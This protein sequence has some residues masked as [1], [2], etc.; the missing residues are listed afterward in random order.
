[1]SRFCSGVSIVNFQQV[2]SCSVIWSRITIIQRPY[3]IS[4]M[5]V[6][7]KTDIRQGPKNVSNSNAM[8]TGS[9]IR[10]EEKWIVAF[11]IVAKLILL[12]MK[13]LCKVTTKK[14]DWNIYDICLQSYSNKYAL[15]CIINFICL[16]VSWVIKN[17]GV[18]K[19]ESPNRRVYFWL[20][21]NNREFAEKKK[22]VLA[23]LLD[24]TLF[25]QVCVWYV[26]SPKI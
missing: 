22:F 14:N 1:M 17:Y 21:P 11:E 5:E 19:S 23:L 4:M 9:I 2:I 10:S 15:S 6:S 26:Q 7:S 20:K 18:H 8:F 24:R 13:I 3:Q 16:Y 12:A 25:K